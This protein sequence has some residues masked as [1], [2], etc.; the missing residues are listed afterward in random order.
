MWERVMMEMTQK[1]YY[2]SKTKH[3]ELFHKFM[4][5]YKR[6]IKTAMVLQSNHL[7]STH[8]NKAMNVVVGYLISKGKHYSTTN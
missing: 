1:D 3:A 6:L 7:W 5:L 2:W 8:Q 4:S